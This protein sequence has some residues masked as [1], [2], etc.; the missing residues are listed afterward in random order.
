MK[1]MTRLLFEPLAKLFRWF[2]DPRFQQLEAR[3]I[4]A[5][6]SLE[7]GLSDTSSM[8]D[9]QSAA[10][11]EV[12]AFL[13]Q[14]ARQV[15]ET[16]A[17]QAERLGEV[18]QSL[19]G[20][21]DWLAGFSDRLEGDREVRSVLEPPSSLSDL[22]A[23][24]ARFLNRAERHDGLAAQ[25]G[26]WFNPPITI[27][28]SPG[29]AEVG[30]VNERIIEM[31]FAL[32]TISA[33]PHGSTILDVGSSESTLAFSLASLGYQV[34]GIDLHPYPLEHPNLE[35]I[36]APL[37]DWEG[38]EGFFDAILCLSSIEHFGLGAYGESPKE[39]L[40][41]A[42]M[43]KLRTL[44]KPGGLLVFTAPFGRYEVTDFQRTYDSEA[45]LNL[46][47]GWQIDVLWLALQRDSTHWELAGGLDQAE[48]VAG[49]G[50]RAVVLL[51]AHEG[52]PS[53]SE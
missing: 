39:G 13:G 31:P 33:L 4:E 45:L 50:K 53:Q 7:R 30:D 24:G 10:I 51:A 28:F 52:Q 26:L 11:S 9:A 6:G 8:L 23:R 44:I 14:R 12:L 17:L 3:I 25:A 48:A 2:F 16:T 35:T 37:E 29:K 5:T 36:A 42:A 38:P 19:G 43:K 15:A 46:L 49:S 32:Q 27:R 1:A 20:L 22:G 21:L 41:V 34:T 47:D 18:Q 40:D